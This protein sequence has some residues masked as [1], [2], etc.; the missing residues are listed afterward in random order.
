M[1]TIDGFLL[2]DVDDLVTAPFWA[3]CAAGELRVQACA[4][5]RRRRFPPRPMCPWCR[6]L[7]STWTAV[8]PTGTVWSFAV[9]HP[10]LLPAYA[11]LAPYVVAVVTLDV[12][13]SIRMVGPI[14]AG[15][16][17]PMGSVPGADVAIGAPV[18][19]TFRDVLPWW[20]L[21]RGG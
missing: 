1:S 16:D 18:R 10:P 7:E 19:A 12:D 11:E 6:S 3:G 20:V 9:A 2:P 5:C 8:P 17:A 21:S 13:A 4:S 15:D 14:V